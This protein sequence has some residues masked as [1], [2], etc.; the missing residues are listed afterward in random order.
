MT[1]LLIIA[2]PGNEAMAE[3]I[4]R[5]LGAEIG[6]LETRQFPDGESYVRHLADPAG[7]HAV[8]VCTLDRPDEKFLRLAFAADAARQLGA[9]SV[10]L[11]APYLAYMRQD[12]RFVAG[13]AIS[14]AT[15][16]NLLSSLVDWL[17]TVDPHLHRYGSL[18]EIYSV[19]TRVVHAAPV[20]STWIKANVSTPLV[21]GPDVESEQ[22][23]SEVARTVGA[24]YR[25]LRKTRT[26]D[27]TVEIE[28]R[29]LSSFAD[30]TPVL[31]D[32]IVSSARTMIET[33]GQLAVHGMRRPLC[34]AVHG[35][36]SE[37]AFGELTA[38]VA[39]VVTTNTVPHPSNAIDI[40]PALS[41]AV[42]D[43]V[44]APPS[45]TENR[46]ERT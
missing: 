10:G 46:K 43:F 42:R 14:S 23:V 35:L 4:A 33:A 1:R 34:V 13:E 41:S 37:A 15:F 11:V 27:R 16:A 2:L 28:V 29:D 5:H 31:V 7:R 22:W 38:S 17:V 30:R 9:A 36:F 12:R 40:A 25:V 3:S 20:L 39:N 32:D 44:A 18:G 45:I 8:L 24:P 19:P 6:R 21:I 26:G